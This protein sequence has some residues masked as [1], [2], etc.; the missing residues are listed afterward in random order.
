MNDNLELNDFLTQEQLV[1][2]F[3]LTSA[4]REVLVRTQTTP[5]QLAVYD[6]NSDIKLSVGKRPDAQLF[7]QKRFWIHQLINLPNV[8]TREDRLLINQFKVPQDWFTYFSNNVVDLAN[9]HGLPKAN[10][11]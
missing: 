3:D 6:N 7:F 10:G 8:N 4:V 2:D 9:I 5:E 1:G 11:W